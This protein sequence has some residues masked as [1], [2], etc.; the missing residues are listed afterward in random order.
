MFCKSFLTTCCQQIAAQIL[1][2]ENEMLRGKPGTLLWTILFG[3]CGTIGLLASQQHNVTTLT[4]KLV[5]VAGIGAESTGWAIRLD[6]AITIRGKAA[7]SIE[8]SGSTKDF[9]ALDKKHVKAKGHL[10]FRRGVERREW[11]V[12][13]VTSIVENKTR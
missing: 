3:S 8:V 1:H 10:T 7:K 2:E 9:E 5:R 6:S 4:G 13:E 12:F 11:P